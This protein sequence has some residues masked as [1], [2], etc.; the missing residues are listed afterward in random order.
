MVLCG[1]Q[2]EDLNAGLINDRV[3]KGSSLNVLE[4][5]SNTGYKNTT[6]KN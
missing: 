6:P 4:P 5:N 2:D 3:T 1:R